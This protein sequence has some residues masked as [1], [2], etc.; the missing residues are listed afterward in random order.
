MGGPKGGAMTADQLEKWK[1]Q[2]E[3]KL[4]Q[5]QQEKH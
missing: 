3:E 2:L 5:Q 4:R 1:R